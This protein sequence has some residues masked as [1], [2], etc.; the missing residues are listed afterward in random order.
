[1]VVGSSP[2]RPTTHPFEWAIITI[3]ASFLVAMCAFLLLE[4]LECITI[5]ACVELSFADQAHAAGDSKKFDFKGC[6]EI[7]L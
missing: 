1:L 6:Q 2:T 3:T 7:M 4:S 5:V